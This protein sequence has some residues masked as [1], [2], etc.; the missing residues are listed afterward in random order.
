MKK[1]IQ[2]A[3]S[4]DRYGDISRNYIKD[5]MS[6][7]IKNFREIVWEKGKKRYLTPAGMRYIL[8]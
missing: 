7:G 5:E 2:D 4:I 8:Q 3:T 6:E 1:E